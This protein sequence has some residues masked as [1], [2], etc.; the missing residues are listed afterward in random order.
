M[1]MEKCITLTKYQFSLDGKDFAEGFIFSDT[2]V[3]EESLFRLGSLHCLHCG[4]KLPV[5]EGAVLNAV[6]D[7]RN[8]DGKLMFHKDHF[9]LSIPRDAAEM[10]KPQDTVKNL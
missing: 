7:G 5:P 9:L 6:I 10:E 4:K 2:D 8:T 3:Y 1:L